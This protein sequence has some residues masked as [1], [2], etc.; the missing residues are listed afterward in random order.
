[1]GPRVEW[2]VALLSEGH[3]DVATASFT[4]GRLSG[5]FGCFVS[6]NATVAERRR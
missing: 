1:M 4:A 5:S 6:G 3:I 2:Q